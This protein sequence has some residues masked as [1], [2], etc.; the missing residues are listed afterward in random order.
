MNT[1]TDTSTEASTDV[2]RN[3]GRRIVAA[4]VLAA[5]SMAGSALLP[6]VVEAGPVDDVEEH[7]VADA[8]G[9]ADSVERWADHCSAVADEYRAAYVDC[10]R[11]APGTADSLERWVG[12]CAGQ[13]ADVMRGN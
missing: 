7:C 13:A 3:G 2:P 4:T 11:N 1:S 5:V 8:A 9:S 6:A 12:H 10:M